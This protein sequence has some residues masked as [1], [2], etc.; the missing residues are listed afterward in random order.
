MKRRIL[1]VD[2]ELNVREGL[3]R[4][5]RNMRNEWEMTF[6][7]SGQ[8][9]LALLAAEPFDVIV[10]DMRMPGMNGAE[11]LKEIQR[12]YPSMV[13]LVLSGHADRELVTQCV[14]VAHQYI[15]KPCD[16]IQL[17]ALVQN[18][19]LLAG[20]LVDKEVRRVIGSINRL[21]SVPELYLSLEA[22]LKD[23]N[24]SV[25]DIGAIIRQDMNM[26]A[27]VL[28]LVNSAFF[29][30][31]RTIETPEEAVSYLGTEMIKVLVLANGVFDRGSSFKTK[32]FSIED[33][34]AHSMGV[35][36]VASA[37]AVA[38]GLPKSV[39]NECSVGGL[40]HDTGLLV[41]AS[42]FPDEYDKVIEMVLEEKISI[43]TSEQWAFG[44]THAEVGAYLLGLWGL[45]TGILQIV[46][47]HHRRPEPTLEPL[48]A[49]PIVHFADLLAGQLC[50]HPMFTDT[51][52]GEKL[53]RFLGSTERMRSWIEAAGEAPRFVP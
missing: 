10:S 29:G 31:R 39:Q 17:K 19:C 28:K 1:F 12:L 36:R 3:Q 46:S 2:D 49:L 33:L 44:V 48:S 5:L 25:Q 18:A 14:G 45:P 6:V 22:A 35:A 24:C 40:L 41:L 13:R 8:S 34:W 26:T 16:P 4:L 9:A 30:L 15:S 27:Q 32:L 52:S 53:A 37:L 51:T 23:E 38:E 20:Q 11:L 43:T 21:P 50:Q 42:N 47:L 7:D